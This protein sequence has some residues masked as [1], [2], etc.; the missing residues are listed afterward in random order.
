MTTAL[1]YW[2][3][4]LFALIGVGQPIAKSRSLAGAAG[5]LLLMA[6]L[7]LIGWKLFGAPIRG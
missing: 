2:I 7:F 1:L 3:L 4:Y 6:L 5:G